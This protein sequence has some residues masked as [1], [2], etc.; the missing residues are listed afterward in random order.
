MARFRGE[1]G[2][3]N[4]VESPEG[5]GVWVDEM[6]EFPYQGDVIRNNRQLENADK[7]N[8]D[9]T[10]SNSISIVCDQYAIDNFMN[11]KYVKWSGTAWTVNSVEVRSP[12]LILSLGGVYNGPKA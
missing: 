7:A 1:V 10:L 4:P 11:I 9:I 12:R 6:V 3:G 5:S 8:S 2:Y